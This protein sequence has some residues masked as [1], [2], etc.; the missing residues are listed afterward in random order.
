M[1]PRAPVWY[2]QAKE[3]NSVRQAIDTTTDSWIAYGISTWHASTC[4]V[5]KLHQGNN[6]IAYGNST[7]RVKYTVYKLLVE[8]MYLVFTRTPC[9]ITVGD[10]DLCW[11]V[12]L[13]V[14]RCYLPLLFLLVCKDFASW[15]LSVLVFFCCCCTP[16]VRT[17]L[18]GQRYFSYAAPSF[19]DSVP[20]E[21]R[22]SNTLSVCFSYPCTCHLSLR[23]QAVNKMPVH[24]N[25]Y[26]NCPI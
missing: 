8:F 7:W 13:S 12:P 9:G 11:C 22:S 26:F 2:R 21:I 19:W 20:C 3:D 25:P 6:R 16:S 1:R 17:H 4:K 10:S 23:P 5:H 18:F 14:E 15:T 24:K